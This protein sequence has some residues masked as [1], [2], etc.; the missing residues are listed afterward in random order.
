[1]HSR[2]VEKVVVDFVEVSD[3]T[4]DVRCDVAPVGKFFDAAPHAHI[5]AFFGWGLDGFG[6]SVAI[7]PLL[8]FDDAGSIVKL[9]G[10]VGVLGGNDLDL[11]DERYLL[12][13]YL[14]KF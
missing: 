1:M 4:N 2:S 9:E 12:R 8:D 14:L 5:L 3:G 6:V 10:Y 11:T 13:E 7:D